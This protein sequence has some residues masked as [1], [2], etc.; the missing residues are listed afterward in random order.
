M[1]EVSSQSAR[2]IDERC[3]AGKRDRF[4]EVFNPATG[5]VENHLLPA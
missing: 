5:S 2:F 1:S 4:G 3:V